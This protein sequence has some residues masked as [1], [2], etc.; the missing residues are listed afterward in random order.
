M[1]ALLADDTRRATM[2]RAARAIAE[3][4]YSRRLQGERYLDLY[5]SMLKG[6]TA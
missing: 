2:G 4:E 6:R 1:H 5:R 3:R